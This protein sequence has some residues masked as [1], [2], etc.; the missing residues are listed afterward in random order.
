VINGVFIHDSAGVLVFAPIDDSSSLAIVGLSNSGDQRLFVSLRIAEK[1]STLIEQILPPRQAVRLTKPLRVEAG[2][3]IC[4]ETVLLDDAMP[5]AA[6]DDDVPE[7]ASVK[8][9]TDWVAEQLAESLNR[10]VIAPVIHERRLML[11]EALATR[12]DEIGRDL[13]PGHRPHV[14]QIAY[15]IGL[16]DAI[17]IMKGAAP[18]HSATP[19]QREY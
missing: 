16:R 9:A 4:A 10:R 8:E 5:P 1:V 13:P 15:A 14:M 6:G 12:A 19:I 2:H 18:P 17:E 3:T 11:L 7:F